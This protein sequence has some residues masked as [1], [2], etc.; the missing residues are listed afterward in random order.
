MSAEESLPYSNTSDVGVWLIRLV[1]T[2]T[3]SPGVP[4][5]TVV[6]TESH[7][8]DTKCISYGLLT[9]LRRRVANV[10][11]RSLGGITTL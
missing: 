10:V 3:P 9:S 6:V 7:V 2:V 8:L 11:S 4:G 1:T 5:R